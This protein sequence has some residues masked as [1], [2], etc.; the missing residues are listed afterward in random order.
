MLIMAGFVLR[1]GI[2]QGWRRFPP[3]LCGLAPHA[4]IVAN[5]FG[6]KDIGI[7]L[8]QVMTT[9]GFVSLGYAVR[10]TNQRG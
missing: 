6:V 4:F 5:I 10:T 2:W 7:I 8:F 9:V 3:F 1:A